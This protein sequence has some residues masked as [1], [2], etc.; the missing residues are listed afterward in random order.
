MISIITISYHAA[1]CIEETILSVL[2]QSYQQFQYIIIDGGS[3]DGTTEIINKYKD[4][5]SYFESE[6]DRGIYDAMNKGISHSTEEWLFFLNAGD[7]FMNNSV[8]QDIFDSKYK[9][10]TT[11]IYSDVV[12]YNSSSKYTRRLF[13]NHKK[14]QLHHQGFIYKRR[15]HDCYGVYLVHNKLSIADYIFFNLLKDETYYKFQN[16]ISI[17]DNTGVSS[18]MKSFYKKISV[19]YLF[20]SI[21]TVKF[22]SVLILYPLYRFA[23]FKI[24]RN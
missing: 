2:N 9:Q 17:I 16:P 18:K 10:D 11:I 3:M 15:L 21:S 14:M 5:I 4:K 22:I 19:D 13:C 20:E 23:K 7:R 1:H 12:L 24:F 8:L 6:P